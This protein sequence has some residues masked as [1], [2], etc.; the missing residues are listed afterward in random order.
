MSSH[1]GAG[2]IVGA[3]L[4]VGAMLCE[5]A[6]VLHAVTG[7]VKKAYWEGLFNLSPGR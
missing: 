2:A 3:G 5:G 7:S 4:E 6:W 1:K